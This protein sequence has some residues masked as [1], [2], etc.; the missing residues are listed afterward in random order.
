MR[1][2]CWPSVRFLDRVTCLKVTTMLMTV[3]TAVTSVWWK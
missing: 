3:K 2:K 1:I